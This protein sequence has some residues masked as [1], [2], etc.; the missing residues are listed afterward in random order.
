VVRK[1]LYV[2]KCAD[3][4]FIMI[5]I[6]SFACHLGQN[7]GLHGLLEKHEINLVWPKGKIGT[8]LILIIL[9]LIKCIQF[10]QYF[11]KDCGRLD[12]PIETYTLPSPSN[13]FWTRQ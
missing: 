13:T 6:Y 10:I 7:L 2:L 3:G 8:V 4:V 11:G 1:L 9:I 12:P 5:F